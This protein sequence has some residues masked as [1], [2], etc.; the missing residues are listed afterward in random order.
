MP[1]IYSQGRSH[2]LVIEC[3]FGII[4]IIDV[5][6]IYGPIISIL[7]GVLPFSSTACLSSLPSLFQFHF[8]KQTAIEVE[9][10]D[11]ARGKLSRFEYVNHGGGARE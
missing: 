2:G 4:A 6:S 1:L 8:K 10:Q 7:L 11:S 5:P 9:F 3:G